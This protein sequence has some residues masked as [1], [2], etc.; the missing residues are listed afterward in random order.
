M[1]GVM[2]VFEEYSPYDKDAQW[3]LAGHLKKWTWFKIY[4]FSKEEQTEFSS[5]RSQYAWVWWIFWSL[6]IIHFCLTQLLL[7]YR[8]RKKR[9]KKWLQLLIFFSISGELLMKMGVWPGQF[10][11]IIYQYCIILTMKILVH[12]NFRHFKLLR[13]QFWPGSTRLEVA[14]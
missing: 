6:L 4:F 7:F 1:S 2:S 14:L 11:I 3:T 12:K 13:E 8:K 9:N 10:L 5:C